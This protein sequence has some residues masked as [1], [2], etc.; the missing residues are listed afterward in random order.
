MPQELVGIL[1]LVLN[2]VLIFAIVWLFILRPDKKRRNELNAMQN[3]LQK[4]DRVITIGGIHGRVH[5]MDET[6]ISLINDAGAVWTFERVAIA[7][8]VD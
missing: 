5:A 4:G 3:S 7:R 1:G 2:F 8:K 6:T